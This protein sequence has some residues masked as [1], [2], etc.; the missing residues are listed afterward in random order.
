MLVL[1]A[2]NMN[3]GWDSK[4]CTQLIVFY[5]K[6]K[7]AGCN[8][9]KVQIKKIGYETLIKKKEI[10]IILIN[11]VDIFYLTGAGWYCRR[12]RLRNRLTVERGAAT[13]AD[14]S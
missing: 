10:M 5:I 13:V 9:L 12:Y 14:Y 2:N 7:L 8:F 4:N 3:I 6:S 11:V 1:F